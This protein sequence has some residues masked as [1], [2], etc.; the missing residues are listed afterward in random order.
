[1]TPPNETATVVP[2][3]TKA[4]V[5]AAYDAAT[6]QDFK[7]LYE[8]VMPARAHPPL[9]EPFYRTAIELGIDPA[10][11]SLMTMRAF[12]VEA[13]REIAED[14]IRWID[15]TPDTVK[16]ADEL[17]GRLYQLPDCWRIRICLRIWRWDWC[18]RPIMFGAALSVA[19]KRGRV[20]SLLTANIDDLEEI[21]DMFHSCDRDGLYLEDLV[22]RRRHERWRKRTVYR[23]AT[24]DPDFVA[25]GLSWTLDYELARWFSR[26]YATADEP[27]HV[28]ATKAP[29]W[30]VLACFEHEDEVV[31]S[32]DASRPYE[33]LDT[34]YEEVPQPWT[35][36]TPAK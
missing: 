22:G 23:G 20:G 6:K 3:I 35:T 7:P 30:A 31:I 34:G 10:D 16:S 25:G 36:E 11:F 15:M 18:D 4:A 27:G 29:K 8:L 13:N 19:H 12:E 17:I 28:V 1:M 24:G 21:V 2:L 33:L 26:R 9:M 14:T 5:R 32:P